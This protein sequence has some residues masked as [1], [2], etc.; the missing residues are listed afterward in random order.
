MFSYDTITR[1]QSERSYYIQVFGDAATNNKK[2]PT[3]TKQ[4]RQDQNQYVLL[5][6]QCG[7]GNYRTDDAILPSPSLY[8]SGFQRWTRPRGRYF[9]HYY[10]NFTKDKSKVKDYWCQLIGN[11]NTNGRGGGGGGDDD[12]NKNDDPSSSSPLNLKAAIFLHGD[13]II[14]TEDDDDD[15]STL[16]PST[17]TYVRDQ[18]SKFYV[19]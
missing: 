11:T 10:H 3:T 13:P 18:L 19:Y 4:R 17:S 5:V 9:R 8:L 7:F 12:K 15:D 14:A 6:G 1:C 2:K 16:S